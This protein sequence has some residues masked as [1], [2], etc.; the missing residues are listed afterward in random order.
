MFRGTVA[1]LPFESECQ[2]LRE[3]QRNITLK[4]GFAVVSRINGM[5]AGR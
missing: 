3:A 1:E 2:E 5:L 4:Q